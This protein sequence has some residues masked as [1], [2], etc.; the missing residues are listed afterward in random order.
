M[1]GPAAE[2]V[3][4]AWAGLPAV[5]RDAVEQA[6]GSPVTGAVTQPGG[7]SPGVAAR[8][9]CADGR[10]FFVKAVSAEAN[11]DSP[12][13][14][15]RESRVLAAL[16]PLAGSGQ[17]PVP[18]LHAVIEEP[19][20]IALLMDDVDGVHPE[21]PWQ[22]GQLAQVLAGIDRLAAALT[23][24]PAEFTAVGLRL[25]RM[26]HGW[27]DLAAAGGADGLDEWSAKHLAELAAIE[28]A[29][30]GH[31]VGR[32]LLHGDLRADNLLL[33]GN[34]VV[35]VDW[36]H[37]STGAAFVD[38]VFLAPSVAMQGGPGLAGLLAGTAAGREASQEAV[39]AVLCA[40]AGYFTSV[41]LKPPPPGLPTLRGFQAAQGRITRGWLAELI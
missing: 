7:F 12:K 27:R 28:A 23:P 26:L 40:L 35:F 10:R 15:R 21:L 41:A 38:L 9:S 22:P 17:V 20:W 13:M 29:W 6:C 5:V 14:H 25:G 1:T 2:G 33:T 32:T 31:S 36:P 18:R 11:P 39:T 3:R 19:P 24:P 37:A 4:V 8:L 34:G 16:G 30:P